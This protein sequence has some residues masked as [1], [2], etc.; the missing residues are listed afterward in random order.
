LRYGWPGLT[1]R[2]DAWASVDTICREIDQWV[3]RNL[4]K[5]RSRPEVVYCYEDVA[6][7]TFAVAGELGIRRIY[8]LPIGHYAAAQRILREETELMPEF[9]SSIEAI[10]DSSY[11][12]RRKDEELRTADTILACSDFVQQTLVEGGVPA[13]KIQVVQYGAPDTVKTRPVKKLNPGRPLQVLF[14]GTVCQRKGIGYLL[15]AMQR[16]QRPDVTLTLLGGMLGDPASYRPY[17]RWF[18]HEPF[19]PYHEG[20]LLMQQADVLVLPTLFEGHAM[21]VLEA[22]MC[23]LPVITTINSGTAHLIKNGQEG[24]IIPIRSIEA[25][26]EKLDWMADH[27]ADVLAMGQA[28]RLRA[29]SCTWENYYRTVTAILDRKT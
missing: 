3:A 1:K 23:G 27:R 24:F 12:L 26:A 25:L 21:V 22:M 18:H 17:A 5:M 7:Q 20:L 19:R 11:K 28:A 29:E 13:N 15:K 16:L 10:H 6:Q 2:E 8:D 9:A 4:Q 14:V